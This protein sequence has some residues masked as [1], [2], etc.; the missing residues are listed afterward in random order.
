MCRHAVIHNNNENNAAVG[1][2]S[3]DVGD[4]GDVVHFRN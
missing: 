1:M 4:V 2:A 3:C